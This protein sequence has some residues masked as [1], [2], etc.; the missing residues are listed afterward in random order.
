M[1]NDRQQI[2][3]TSFSKNQVVMAISAV[4][5]GYFINSYF[6]QSLQPAIPRIADALNGFDL[7]SWSISIPAL[8]LA[9]ATLL[10]G[11]LSDIYGRRALLM[12]AMILILLGT[13]WCCFCT[14]MKIFIIARTLQSLGLG[15]VS[16]LCFTVI[17][18]IFSGA[19]QRSRWMGMLGL[20]AGLALI[21][22]VVGP[23]F[24]D[25]QVW[26]MIFW[27]SLPFIALC[28]IFIS[29]M[30]ALVQGTVGKIDVSGIV[31]IILASSAIILGLSL[32]GI[33]VPWGSMKVIGLLG[34]AVIVGILFLLAE[35]K[36]K[37]PFLYLDLLKNRTFM[38][39]SIAG[40]LSFF[41][42][43]SIGVYFQAFMQAIQNR[44]TTESAWIGQFPVSVLMAFI[45]IPVGFLVGRTKRYKGLIITGYALAAAAMMGMILLSNDTSWLWELLIAVI[46]GLGLGAIPTINTLLIPAAVPRRLMGSAMAVL[47]FSIS[48]GMAV[49]V[50][51][52][53]SVM[54]IRYINTLK[55]SLPAAVAE[56]REIM[57]TISDYHVLVNAEKLKALQAD[58]DKLNNAGL[59][60]FKQTESSIRSSAEAGLK[61]VF[62]IGGLTMALA[63]LLILTLPVIPLDRPP[64]Q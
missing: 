29:R 12:S 38:T 59:D 37:E 19:V 34:A 48:I 35:S 30:P 56:N 31:L 5:L 54:N 9:I 13:I 44:L 7:F 3:G 58:V 63:F 36:A 1:A 60:L 61:A 10:A 26:K 6:M 21:G 41:G 49:A 24:V 14:T 27:F 62:I 17:G 52:Q 43:T 42:M 20:P 25:H 2:E 46:A 55:A 64:E 15:I 18:D 16:P 28:M 50:A 33:G 8:G 32:P 4:F 53:G 11:K 51:I 57:F 40:F 23:W 45:G 39:I 22:L 47:F